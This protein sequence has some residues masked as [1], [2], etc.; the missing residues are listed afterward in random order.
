MKT[1]QNLKPGA[2]L[3]KGVCVLG[4]ALVAGAVCAANVVTHEAPRF[5]L[6]E[7]PPPVAG[8]ARLLPDWAALTNAAAVADA[9]TP[10]ESTLPAEFIAPGAVRL[11]VDFTATKAERA[12]WDLKFPCDLRSAPGIEFDFV[13]DDLSQFTSFCCYFKSGKGWYKATFAPDEDGVWRH[14][15][16]PKSRFRKEGEVGGWDRVTAMRISCWRAGTNRTV[17]AIANVAASGRES[18]SERERMRKERRTVLLDW[19]ADRPS[20]AG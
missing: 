10:G 15:R 14:V 1:S 5:S 6:P 13:C 20:K 18:T 17:C 7:P 8:G 9:F 12:S 16:I 2:L 19:L 3:R 11:P 4:A